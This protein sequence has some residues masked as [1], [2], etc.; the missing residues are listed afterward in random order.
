MDSG[1]NPAIETFGE[2]AKLWAPPPRLTVSEWADKNRRLARES[3]ARAGDWVTR[4]YQREPM[5]AFSDP[6]VH[7][8]VLMVARQTL[9]T[10]V[11]NNCIG[12]R[13]DQDPGRL[14]E[15]E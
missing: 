2:L 10:E 12:Y 13:I 15:L 3:S 14:S 5:D 1:M 7:T 6:K 9:K 11:I 4:A 8:I